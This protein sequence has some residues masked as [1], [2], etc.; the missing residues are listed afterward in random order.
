MSRG[1]HAF[2]PDEG[3]YHRKPQL[4]AI[5]RA[6]TVVEERLGLIPRTPHPARPSGSLAFLI[7]A[8]KAADRCILA[9]MERLP[10]W[11]KVRP[12]ADVKVGER[13]YT[14]GSPEGLEL[15]LAEGIV[16]PKRIFRGGRY[17]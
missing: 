16:S 17:V 4:F 7:S 15:S 1:A 14:I 6:L 2:L 3:D 13:V 10:V 11:D 5:H 12:Y 9:L 8:D